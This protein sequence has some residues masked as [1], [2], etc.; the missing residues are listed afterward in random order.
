MSS[1]NFWPEAGRSDHRVIGVIC[2]C[3]LHTLAK[4]GQ[5]TL[6]GLVVV[7]VAVEVEASCFPCQ[8][9]LMLALQKQ[10]VVQM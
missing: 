4:P 10:T 1:R 3:C 8:I 5:L 7:E 2:G 6:T 9:H